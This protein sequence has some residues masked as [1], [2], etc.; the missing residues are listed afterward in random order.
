[1]ETLCGD[2]KINFLYAKCRYINPCCF[3]DWRINIGMYCDS[4]TCH[5]WK[6]VHFGIS[7]LKCTHN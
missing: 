2:A 7:L 1:M 5:V 4:L 3:T 6:N